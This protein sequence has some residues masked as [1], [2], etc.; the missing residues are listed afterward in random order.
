VNASLE[1][2]PGTLSAMSETKEIIPGLN[3]ERLKEASQIQMRSV[4]LKQLYDQKQITK[5]F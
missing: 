2:I 3:I 1:V 4:Y 5:D